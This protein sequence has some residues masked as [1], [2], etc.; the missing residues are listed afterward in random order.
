MSKLILKAFIFLLFLFTV[1]ILI[2]SI[3]VYPCTTQGMSM[4]PTISPNET[5]LTNRWKVLTGQE[6][7]RGDIIIFEIPSITYISQNQYNPQ[8][9][10][11][12]YDNK[13]NINIFRERWLKRVIGLAGDHIQ[14][15]ENNELYRNGE[16]IG[17]ATRSGYEDFMYIDVIVPENSF[18]VMGDNRRE[19]L[20]SRSFGCVPIEQVYSVLF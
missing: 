17:Y 16:M 18:Y 15:T 10:S 8:N 6:I 2:I 9:Q 3:F 5:K 1:Y 11:A 4:F 19:S 14:I 13:F 7:K 20:D 12:Q